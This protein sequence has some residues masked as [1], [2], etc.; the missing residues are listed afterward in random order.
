[1]NEIESGLRCLQSGDLEQAEKLFNQAIELYPDEY[2]PYYYRGFIAYKKTDYIKAVDFFKKALS[3][4]NKNPQLNFSLGLVYKEIKNLEEAQ[5]H[6]KTAIELNPDYIDAYNNLANLYLGEEQHDEAIYWYKKLKEREPDHLQAS[7]MLAIIYKNQNKIYEA[8]NSYLE[9]IRI[10]PDYLD[11]YIDLLEL[12]TEAK[13]ND[14]ALEC[15]FKM[16]ELQPDDERT[17]L[18]IGNI[19]KDTENYDEA[20]LY[21]QKAAELKSDYTEAY[22]N[23]GLIYKEKDLLDD[24]ILYYQKA[25]DLKPDY[26]PAY[27]NLGVVYRAKNKISEAINCYKK[28]IALNP[29]YPEAVFNLGCVNLSIENF[30]EGWKDFEQ[31]LTL[32]EIKAGKRPDFKT[33]EWQGESL[34]NKTIY[35]HCSQAF[36]DTIQFVR[37]VPKL[38]EM[39]ANV[40]LSVQPSLLELF[41]QSNLKESFLVSNSEDH[42]ALN[43]DTQISLLNLPCRFGT[44]QNNATYKEGY[45][46]ANKEKT[47]WY[48]QNYF[49]NNNLKLGIYWQGDQSHL[50]NRAL[51]LSYYYDFARLPNTKLYSFQKGYGVEQLDDV[52]DDIEIVRL[53][54]TFNDFADTASALENIDLLIT[55]DTSIAHLA[56]AIGKPAWV[57]LPYA[58]EWRWLLAAGE[59]YWYT[60]L[61]LFRQ[62]ESMSWDKPIREIMAEL[63][64]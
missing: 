10:A 9:V 34:E 31:G 24:A 7:L 51:P 64:S 57:L 52:P 49:N 50:K 62:D 32:K 36:G 16:L 30:S 4:N 56:G 19:L 13:D 17:Y 33:S 55:I 58:P 21:Y 60:S 44:N 59:S 41:K 26:A 61:K 22:Y 29:S 27:N 14:M 8:V 15:C 18:S 3:L 63:Q 25:I 37:Y 53:G 11:A 47:D 28:A 20:L 54:D 39:G 46:R 6:Y 42:S 23:I 2:S 43:F 38:S 5:N 12:C 48:K 1:M 45:L 40:I 35:V